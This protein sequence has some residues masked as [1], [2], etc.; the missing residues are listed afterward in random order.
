MCVCCFL[1]LFFTKNIHCWYS[2][3]SPRYAIQLIT[4]KVCTDTEIAGYHNLPR[5]IVNFTSVPDKLI[6]FCKTLAVPITAIADDI[7]IVYYFAEKKRL[8]VSRESSVCQTVH[9]Q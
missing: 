3:E 5:K 8:D 6:L 7:L 1:L 4:H 9:I 2:L